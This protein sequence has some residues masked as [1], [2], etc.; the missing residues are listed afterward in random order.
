MWAFLS[1]AIPDSLLRSRYLNF[2]LGDRRL[3]GFGMLLTAVAGFGNTFFIGLFGNDIRAAFGLSHGDFGLI[4][5][6]ASLLSGLCLPWLG[7]KI[8]HLDLRIYTSLIFGGLAAGASSLSLASSIPILASALFILRLAGPALMGHT[9]VTSMGRYFGGNR[10]KAI[11]VA[12]LGQPLGEAVLPILAI[13]VVAAFGWRATWMAAGAFVGLICL[14]LMRWL[15]RDHAG[16]H[17]RIVSS[18]EAVGSGTSGRSWSRREA[19]RHWHFYVITLSLFLSYFIVTG[20]LFHQAHLAESKGWSLAWVAYCFLAFAAAKVAAVL[21]AGAL[22][23]R[24]SAKF[25]MPF[26]L[27][28]LGL[29]L[30]ILAVFDHPAFAALYLFGAGLSAGLCITIAGA[31]WAEIY[32]VRHLGA[33]R[34]MAQSVTFVSSALAPVVMG[35][36]FDRGISVATVALACASSIVA[37]SALAVPL[38]RTRHQSNG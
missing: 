19:L 12:L 1:R 17:A 8:D 20:L 15:L 5:T 30:L 26:F 16:R 33:I 22:I 37:A 3:I 28:P 6:I 24:F 38:L 27:L 4:Y 25:L 23:D 10:G 29:S 18:A 32:G 34:S 7:R 36:L 14:P 31:I 2:V 35:G 21:I 13:T 11:G 9:A